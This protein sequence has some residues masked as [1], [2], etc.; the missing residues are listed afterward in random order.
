VV[1]NWTYPYSLV[2]NPD[3]GEEEW[4][5][6][7]RPGICTGTGWR[8][9]HRHHPKYLW[10]G[11]GYLSI[12]RLANADTW[13]RYAHRHRDPDLEAFP[14]RPGTPSNPNARLEIDQPDAS[15]ANNPSHFRDLG[16]VSL[17]PGS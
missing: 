8:Q 13:I 17:N 5:S 2:L 7:A 11:N 4:F 12:E 1:K 3:D 14:L 15:N 9:H 6:P 10:L 16:F